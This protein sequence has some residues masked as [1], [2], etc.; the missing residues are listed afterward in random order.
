MFFT[1]KNLYK[2][3]KILNKSLDKATKIWYNRIKYINFI[4]YK[5]KD[6]EHDT[7]YYVSK[8]NRELAQRVSGLFIIYY[9]IPK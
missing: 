3:L 9:I 1:L 2:N 4:F 5:V 8:I 6:V 7:K